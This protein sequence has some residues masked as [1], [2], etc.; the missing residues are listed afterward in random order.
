M[1]QIK[2]EI[3]INAPKEEVWGVLGDFGGISKW[4]P[5]VA[6][7]TSTTTANEGVGCGRECEVPGFG[8]LR[9]QVTEWDE[10]SRIKFN[11]EGVGP[12]KSMIN[13]F[14]IISD[15]KDTLATMTVNFQMKFGLIGALMD[16]LKVRRQMR[17][18]VKLTLAGLKH[19]VETGELVTLKVLENFTKLSK[20]A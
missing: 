13:E 12:M 4:S 5:T 8:N 19:H 16:R 2:S 18:L 11:I 17:K 14:S 3:K 6:K 15:G 10:G 7:S 9:E 20:A 1:T